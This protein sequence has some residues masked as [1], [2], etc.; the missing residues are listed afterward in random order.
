MAG[1]WRRRRWRVRCRPP[2][3]HHPTHSNPPAHAAAAALAAAQNATTVTTGPGCASL[4]SIFLPQLA[5]LAPPQAGAICDWLQHG[6]LRTCNA[7]AMLE[8]ANAN[9]KSDANTTTTKSSAAAKNGRCGADTQLE[10]RGAPTPFADA[11]PLPATFADP[12]QV[13][14]SEGETLYWCGRAWGGRGRG[15]GGAGQGRAGR[16]LRHRRRSYNRTPPRM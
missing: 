15:S 3:T 16:V 13:F 1:G 6:Q 12:A 14:Q 9:T 10:P 4:P 11:R 5:T 8:Y 2:P 7:L